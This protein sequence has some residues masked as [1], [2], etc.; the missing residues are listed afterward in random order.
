MNSRV[1]NR[2][3]VFAFAALWISA[4]AF[5]QATK[6][7]PAAPAAP[8]KAAQAAAEKLDINTATKDQLMK[9][10]GIGEAYSQKIIDG[11]PYKAKNELTQKKIIPDA[12]YTKISDL[13]IAKQVP[14]AATTKAATPSSTTKAPAAP[15]KK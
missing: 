11:R 5:A 10:P 13:I 7:T 3:V 4:T 6:S 14:A 9:L 2:F 12:T 1:S 8:A 15:A